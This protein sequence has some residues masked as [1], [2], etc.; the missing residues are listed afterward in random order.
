MR[1]HKHIAAKARVLPHP[2]T[3][4][5]TCCEVV[6]HRPTPNLPEGWAA[7]ECGGDVYA[8]CHECAIDLPKGQIQ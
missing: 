4:Q 8:Y 6:E 7:E 2:F 5:C 1:T 3:F